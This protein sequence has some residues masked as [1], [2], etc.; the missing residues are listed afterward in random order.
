MEP[1][2]RSPPVVT[3]IF[4]PVPIWPPSLLRTSKVNAPPPLMV[5]FAPVFS[6]IFPPVPIVPPLLSLMVR[7]KLPSLTVR[8]VPIS[9]LMFAPSVS[10]TPGS[11]VVSTTTSDALKEPPVANVMLPPFAASAMTSLVAA[12]DPPMAMFP[13]SETEILPPA[14]RVENWPPRIR[15]VPAL[16]VMFRPAYRNKSVV[17]DDWRRQR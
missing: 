15:S 17:P 14:L 11:T 16:N 13:L 8:L 2:V 7:D 10:V 3:E 5:R 1:A 9:K 12:S 6:V 4:P